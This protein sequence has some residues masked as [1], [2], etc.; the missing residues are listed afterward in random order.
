MTSHCSCGTL[1]MCAYCQFEG[2]GVLTVPD[3]RWFQFVACN[4]AQSKTVFLSLKALKS[5]IDFVSLW[6]KDLL[7]IFP[8][9]G[10]FI[11]IKYLLW[12]VIFLYNQLI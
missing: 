10:G 5:A 4:I 3:H 2:L 8:E 11:H 6:M 9:P 1:A 12:Q 7:G